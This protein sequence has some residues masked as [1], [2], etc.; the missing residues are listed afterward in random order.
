MSDH[1]DQLRARIQ[2]L[3]EESAQLKVELQAERMREAR[4]RFSCTCVRLNMDI[5]IYN[6]IDQEKARRDGLGL[7]S[8][9]LSADRACRICCGKGVPNVQQDVSA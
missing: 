4:A 5:G 2:K 9:T 3:D 1:A 8:E 6:M 7:V